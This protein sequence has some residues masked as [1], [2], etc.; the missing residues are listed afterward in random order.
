M[1][2]LTSSSCRSGAAPPTSITKKHRTHQAGAEHQQPPPHASLGL[3]LPPPSPRS[4][5]HTRQG[6]GTID[7]LLM[8]VWGRATHHTAQSAAGPP[9]QSSR[10]ALSLARMATNAKVVRE[11]HE[12]RREDLLQRQGLHMSANH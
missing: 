10:N 1:A 6:H 12:D 2:P 9:K 5:A 4:I 7:L 11:T 8:P 3:H